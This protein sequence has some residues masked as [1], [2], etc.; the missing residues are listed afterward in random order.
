[1]S[2]T[3]RSSSRRVVSSRSRWKNGPFALKRSIPM[4]QRGGSG[5]YHH[6]L[7][8]GLSRG[9]S[10]ET[11]N[12]ASQMTRRP[13]ARPDSSLET[14]DCE[15]PHRSARACCVRRRSRRRVRVSRPSSRSASPD[16]SSIGPARCATRRVQHATPTARSSAASP[17][18]PRWSPSVANRA[19]MHLQASSGGGYSCERPRQ[20]AAANAHSRS[21]TPGADTP[22]AATSDG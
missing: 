16:H 22:P 14:V 21:G 9:G 13:G 7:P 8:A 1:M 20:A 19:R 11:S 15:I 5:W 12:R 3:W 6:G 2:R 17:R 4:R 10:R 18:P